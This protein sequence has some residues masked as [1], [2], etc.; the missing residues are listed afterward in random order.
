[1]KKIMSIDELR[2]FSTSVNKNENR[3]LIDTFNKSIENYNFGIVKNYNKN[4][5][6]YEVYLYVEIDNEIVSP[7]L[8][9]YF[10]N[11][12]IANTYYKFLVYSIDNQDKYNILKKISFLVY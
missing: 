1:M 6:K 9:R 4:K 2:Q 7:L 11:K 10:S 3:E 5:D 12:L 8:I